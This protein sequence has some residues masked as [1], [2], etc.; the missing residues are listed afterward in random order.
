M[1]RLCLSAHISAVTLVTIRWQLLFTLCSSCYISHTM[2]VRK[3]TS[4]ALLV[5]ICWPV[6]MLVTIHWPGSG[7]VCYVMLVSYAGHIM[8]VQISYCGYVV[9]VLQWYSAGQVMLVK[10]C[11]SGYVGQIMLVKLC[12]LGYVDQVMLVKLCWFGYVG[13]VTMARLRWPVYIV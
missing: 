6:I 13:Q 8:L 7:H 9:H 12:W 1:V 4:R 2:L 3:N 11:W 10:L 5:K